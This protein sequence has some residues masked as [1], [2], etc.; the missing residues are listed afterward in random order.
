MRRPVVVALLLACAGPAWAQ[1]SPD[2]GAPGDLEASKLSKVPRQRKFVA[3]EYP[4]AAKTQRIEAEVVLL[5]DLDEQGLVT[6]ASVSEPARPAGMGFDEAA[7]AAAAGWEF[8]PAEVDGKPIAVQITYRY[9]FT[10]APAP[11]PAKAP[12]RTPVANF[13]GRLIERGTRLP[14]PGVV[15]TVFRDDV[16]P[17][18]G[19]EAAAD[20]EG[21]FVF[22]DLAPGSWKVLVDAP[23]Y[24]P[25]RTTETVTE[26]VRLDAKYYLEK[27]SYNPLDVTVTGTRPRKEVSRTVIRAEEIDLIPGG[28]G[29]PLAVVENFAGVARA[30]NPGELAVR[31]SAPED[32]KI[33]VDGAEVPL[34]YH[35]G[36]LKSVLPIG[37]IESLE[38][39]PGNF[40]P[41]YGRATGGI[42]DVQIKRLQPK[43][44]GGYVDVSLL[45]AGFYLEAPLGKRA[46]FAIAARRSYIDAIVRAAIPEGS[47]ISLTTAPRYY[48]FQAIATFR[49][50][51]AHDLRFFAFGSDDRLAALLDNPAT[52][53]STLD[54][55]SLS[56]VTT[57]GRAILE[58]RYVPSSTFE[59]STKLAIGLDDQTFNAGQLSFD[60]QLTTGQARGVMRWK[61]SRQL[62]LSTGLDVLAQTSD[63]F[64][65]ATRPP[66]E[67]QPATNEDLSNTLT[68]RRDD[69]FGFSPAG[70]V[71]AELESLAGLVILPGLRV[72]RFA[73]TSQTV[74]QPRLTARWKAADPLTLKGGVGLFAQEPQ[75]FELDPTFGNPD[76][77]VEKAWHFSAGAEWKP[78]SWLTFDATGFYKVLSNLVSPTDALTTDAMGTPRALQYDNEG[79][80]RV[81]GLELT[82]RHEFA[83]NFNGWVAYTLSRSTRRDSGERESR[84]FDQD[85]THILTV[86]GSYR[87]PRNWQI[88]GRFRLISGNPRTPVTGAIYDAGADRYDPV[89]GETN[90]ARD[91]AFH[92][93]DLRVDK[94][95]IFR[96][97]T[98]NVYLDIQNVYNQTNGDGL[99]YNFDYSQAQES[100]GI[101]IFPILGVRGEL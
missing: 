19:F 16:A 35:F 40:S 78:A 47:G 21:V 41:S 82:A 81:V 23:G 84:L 1:D 94:R 91:G 80:G 61:P 24:F 49:P 12:P 31:G 44:I 13:T 79:S 100:T 73:G 70:F 6:S 15:V 17:P 34:I 7:L 46:A 64:I 98:L 53:D 48:D 57:F 101:P 65:R 93:L 77:E 83:H 32:T 43:K 5:L 56:N 27:K 50:T 29:D 37:V 74:V 62:T 92:Q 30:V 66:A 18:V 85:Q 89:Y 25:Y 45:D 42:I 60:R 51:A 9:R 20:A 90:S 54:G 11:A 87:L 76:L 95:W 67:G 86:V 69:V 63:L 4:E 68:T 88:G 99:E 2:A 8:E 52:I 59:T 55:N 39:Y 75:F 26:A 38:F 22:Y 14:L 28:G 33:F 36:G 58:H 72:D 97:W 10:L 71:E 3:A 96:D